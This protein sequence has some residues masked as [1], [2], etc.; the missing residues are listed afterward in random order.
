MKDKKQFNLLV[1]IP[2]G[3][4]GALCGLWG[5]YGLLMSLMRIGNIMHGFIFW[6]LLFF[7]SGLLFLMGA[8]LVGGTIM[9]IM[10]NSAKPETV[11]KLT[12]ILKKVYIVDAIL[13]VL[14]IFY[15]LV[16]IIPNIF[17][18]FFFR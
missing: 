10:K 13:G 9:T 17:P 6:L 3:I 16:R 18:E 8:A 1:A 11:E 15:A 14:V 12:G 4:V 5:L 7:G 2:Q